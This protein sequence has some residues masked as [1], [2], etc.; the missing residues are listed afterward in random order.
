MSPHGYRITSNK[1]LIEALKPTLCEIPEK[2]I[3]LANNFC[4]SKS[5]NWPVVDGEQIFL[6]YPDEQNAIPGTKD[7]C[8]VYINWTHKLNVQP[9]DYFDLLTRH[10]G[11]LEKLSTFCWSVKKAISG[12]GPNDSI[13]P[14]PPKIPEA[15]TNPPP[16]PSTS[17]LDDILKFIYNY[18][19]IELIILTVA[20]AITALTV[21]S[22][23]LRKAVKGAIKE[24][25]EWTTLAR[26]FKKPEVTSNDG[27]VLTQLQGLILKKGFKAEGVLFNKQTVIAQKYLAYLANEKWKELGNYRKNSFLKGGR[28]LVPGG[29]PDAFIEKFAKEYFKTQ[30][31]N[32]LSSAAYEWA[33][34]FKLPS[35]A[36][37]VRPEAKIVKNQLIAAARL[38]EEPS[39]VQPYI[40]RLAFDAI[41][42]WNNLD[43]RKQSFFVDITYEPKDGELPPKFIEDFIIKNGDFTNIKRFADIYTQII[44]AE[45]RLFKMSGSDVIALVKRVA[46]S[47]NK[48]PNGVK[49][50]FGRAINTG[51]LPPK[52]ISHIKPWLA[53]AAPLISHE[54]QPAAASMSLPLD[55]KDEEKMSLSSMRTMEKWPT[56]M[57]SPKDFKLSHEKLKDDWSRLPD[58]IRNAFLTEDRLMGVKSMLSNIPKTYVDFWVATH[59]DMEDSN[60]STIVADAKDPTKPKGGPGN[61]GAS[62]GGEAPPVPPKGA[63]SAPS[64]PASTGGD[65]TKG[66]HSTL[67][68][69]KSAVLFSE[70]L[71]GDLS[72]A[73][74][75]DSFNGAPAFKGIETFAGAR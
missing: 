67:T 28:G 24:F 22:K 18:K 55:K 34:N 60:S 75:F 15:I 69:S 59:P 66:A 13:Q 56:P 8:D 10:H 17:R 68:S 26:F 61:S 41:R 38:T 31:M 43:F 33:K 20:V 2:Q 3:Y 50:S 48:L 12:T 65:K 37:Q 25:F 71:G 6:A 21:V 27:V 51:Q 19:K 63:P 7:F 36:S 5:E 44:E 70:G 29:L 1:Y 35:I 11:D 73:T 14:G 64:S 58:E 42:T 32:A 9:A 46:S 47:W 72:A 74:D 49:K 39:E 52:F 62:G 57:Q 4:S 23:K 53:D 40:E 30:K 45:P 16:S 54:T